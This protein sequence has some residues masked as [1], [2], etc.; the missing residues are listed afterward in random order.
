MT[1]STDRIGLAQFLLDLR[2]ELN[3]AQSRA[4][5]D[6]L[7]LGVEEVSLTLD[8]GYTL[9]RAGGAAA[10]VKAKFWVF[11]SAEAGA[12]VGVSSE[13]MRTQQLTLTLK[14]RLEQVVVDE[15]GNRTTVTRGV[16]VAGAFADGEERPDLPLPGGP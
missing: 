14:P 13:R 4:A 8:V 2:A 6:S 5:D 3:E 1:D 12:T 16:D 15:H 9:T 7:K 10:N 11:A